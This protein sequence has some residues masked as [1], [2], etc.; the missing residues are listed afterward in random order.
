M[1]G[2]AGMV[3]GDG[4]APD[5]RVLEKMAA[6]LAFRGPDA[7]QVSVRS[8]AGF[9][10][11]LLRTGPAPQA[12][13]QPCSLDGRTWLI[14]DVRLDGR[15]ELRRELG[16]RGESISAEATD[17]ELILHA[18]RQW[19]EASFEKLLGDLAVAVW[20][21]VAKTLWCARDL[22]GIRP[23]LY[24]QAGQ[25]IYFSNT[26][27][28][29]R[30]APEVTAALDPRF[31]GDF[32][33]QGFCQEAER[34]VFRGIRR[35]PQGH[36]LKFS[37]GDARVRQYAT[38]PIEEPLRLKRDAEYVE[39]FRG[40]LEQAVRDRLPRGP[41]AI[42]MSGGLDSTSVAAHAARIARERGSG[43]S[44]RAYTVDMRPLFADEEAA[45]AA[46]AGQHLGIPVEVHSIGDATP[47]ASWSDANL[48]LP[49]P[50][51]EAF[52]VPHRDLCREISK[53]TRVA[54]T[55]DGGDNVLTGQAW[56]YLKYLLRKMQ[57]GTIAGVFGGYVL[58]HRRIPPLHGGFRTRWR[59]WTSRSDAMEGY[60]SWL[61]SKFESEQQLHDR[62][63]ELQE[64][65]KTLHPLHPI[66]YASLTSSYWA[67]VL[68][69]EDAPWTGIALESRGPLLD[70]RVI[71]FLLRVPP[72]P[73]CME[74]KLLREAMKGMLP[75]EVVRREKTPLQ[76]EPLQVFARERGWRPPLLSKPGD[77]LRAFVNCE[78]L[79][80]T[81]LGGSG[82]SVWVDSRPMSLLQWL[83]GI[84][85]VE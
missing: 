39:Q 56:P 67:Y 75:D 37:A 44:I 21:E 7:K 47:F 70:L 54:L 82:S 17:E 57:I 65:P 14:G 52:L 20:D 85:K 31:I 74:K 43:H 27:D 1:S 61:D 51:H 33:L 58:K 9:C 6:G 71:R 80:A 19:G 40:L 77:S 8:G 12:E 62:W 55:G 22:L 69:E 30:L 29:L 42:F 53:H 79:C 45:Y 60:P 4:S 2:F 5:S 46:R 76:E 72:V 78:K 50:S 18:W 59:K 32:L 48:R 73:W 15:E 66:A 26:L 64:P 13:V 38:L 3:N 63:R 25:R 16:Q 41:V 36:F 34:T 84:E 24:A 35:L 49:E 11:T 10:F 68:E 83:K 28:V 81:L 23:F